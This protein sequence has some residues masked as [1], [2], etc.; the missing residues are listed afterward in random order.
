MINLVKRLELDGQAY[1]V[2]ADEV[3]LSLE[4]FQPDDEAGPPGPGAVAGD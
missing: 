4:A 1:P 2:V 3:P